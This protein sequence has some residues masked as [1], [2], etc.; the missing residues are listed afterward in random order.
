MD[1][2]YS[3]DDYCDEVVKFIKDNR[4]KRPHVIAHSFGGRIAVKLAALNP[5]LFGKIVLTGAAGLKPRPSVKKTVKRLAFKAVKPFIKKQKLEWFYSSD[6]RAL[7]PVMRQS[8]VKIVNEHLDT[9][10]GKIT[11][12]TLVINGKDDK[13]TPPYFARRYNRLIK[14]SRLILIWGAG[15]FCFI[16]KPIKFNTEVKEFL[17]S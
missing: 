9:L 4:L 13:E 17:L 3:L 5:D 16:D 2:P 12:Q 11:N 7:S 8:F 15:H 14:N 10:A 6:Y 1:F